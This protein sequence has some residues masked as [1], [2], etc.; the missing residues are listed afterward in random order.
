MLA[1]I[2]RNASLIKSESA[3]KRIAF[4]VPQGCLV[5][6]QLGD[7]NK[8]STKSAN[9]AQIQKRMLEIVL[10]GV[11]TPLIVLKQL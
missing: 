11:K 2:H 8:E 7:S 3:P 6:D 4:A 5:T 10:Y 9:D 1:K